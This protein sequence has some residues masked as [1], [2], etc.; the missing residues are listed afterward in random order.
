[1]TNPGR[2]SVLLR[3][4][5]GSRRVSRTWVAG[6]ECVTRVL[7]STQVPTDL[8][9]LVEKIVLHG[10][11]SMLGLIPD[12]LQLTLEGYRVAAWLPSDLGPPLPWTVAVAAGVD[13][14][15]HVSISTGW[16]EGD[17]L[18]LLPA[19]S[20]EVARARALDALRILVALHACLVTYGDFKSEN[21]VLRPDGSIALIDLD[22]LREV[23]HATS[24]APTRDL[25]RSWAA[26]E[27]ER[28]QRTYLA[29]DLWSWAQLV[30]HLFPA[31]AP[32]EWRSALDACRL[33]DPLR[34]P[35]T[36]YLLAHLE[37]GA[38]LVDWLD[39]PTP[40]PP[41]TATE[42][43]PEVTSSFSPS[44]TSPGGRAP[45]ETE[46]VPERTGDTGG[47]GFRE[48][49]STGTHT[50]ATTVAPRRVQAGCLW[51]AFAAIA[52][53]MLTCGGLAF[54]WDQSRIADANTAAAEALEAMKA[55]KTR[56]ELN[57]DRS[58][59]EKL[60][61]MAEDAWAIRETPRSAAVRA[62][63]TV[64]AQGFQ[65]SSEGWKPERYEAA[66]AAIEPVASSRQPEAQLARGTLDAAVCR[67][68]RL[69]TTAPVHCGRAL[70]GLEELQEALPA[71]AEHHWLR[72][73]AAWTEVLV[74]S[75]LVS[76]ARNAGLP[77]DAKQLDAGRA[78]CTQAE[79]WLPYAPVNGPELFQDCLRLASA[80]LDVDQYLH[81]AD[82]LVR[83]DMADGAVKKS[84]IKH[85]YV[86]GG[87]GCESSTV[88][89][90]RR[91]EWPVKGK[92]WC[93]ALGHAARGC[94]DSAA[95]VVY[96]DRSDD[97]DHPWDT[98]L[99]SAPHGTPSTCVR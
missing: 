80:A 68:N 30:E 61:T 54:T 49:T 16:I 73:E 42:R 47:V 41:G 35:R 77:S 6:Q 75:E 45:F 82:L 91:G 84:T 15:G 12:D 70:A 88:D 36:E 37:L 23:A 78:R 50:T 1:M 7:L 67:L 58:Q 81:W 71:D 72:M 96:R 8:G 52:L 66:L 62:L 39:R 9:P 48:V 95:T 11:G 97:P 56:P 92:P 24:Y 5:P 32:A 93:L 59:R 31:G 98:L 57:K 44:P 18:H 64:W 17:P 19:P 28:D 55:N 2:P 74:R 86:G 79:A 34:R 13:A 38:P 85:L 83:A 33:H 65:D 27:Q 69:D 29:S 4:V 51:G 21:L 99:A 60:R 10:H 22:T 20:P 53:L 87:I 3:E 43:M 76:Q 90:K 63:A 94:W 46:R 25:T 40:P 26:P 14:E 89:D